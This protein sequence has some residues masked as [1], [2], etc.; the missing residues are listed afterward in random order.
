MITMMYPIIAISTLVICVML[1]TQHESDWDSL[2]FKEICL[3]AFNSYLR[4]WVSNRFCQYALLG[5]GSFFKK[6]N[7][8]DD[9][10]TNMKRIHL[11]MGLFGFASLLIF[12][13]FGSFLLGFLT[14]VMISYIQ[15]KKLQNNEREK[16]IKELPD[17]FRTMGMMLASGK[18][19]MQS[20]SY[21]ADHSDG[22]ISRAFGACAISMQLGESR[23]VA[24]RSLATSLDI[25]CMKLITCSIEVS[26]LTGAPLQDLLYKAALLLE[27]QQKI[28]EF[29]RVKTSQ[30]QASVKVV[31][32]LPVIIV[33][34]L[35]LL[36]PEF[37]EGLMTQAGIV[38]LLVAGL[39]DI[40]AIVLI[41]RLMRGVERDVVS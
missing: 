2:S 35:A 25:E 10:R 38:S 4:F 17:T 15:G 14:P 3:K 39:L 5:V 11:L 28:T 36:S 31:V 9:L 32:F 13:S 6:E 24:L 8:E 27:D 33:F 18:T 21:I 37:R 20:C 23:E 26:Q 29:I 7:V 16:L 41:R 30:A 19:L 34:A 40:V 12:R 22:V 1:C